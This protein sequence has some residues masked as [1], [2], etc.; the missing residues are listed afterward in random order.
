MQKWERGGA[1]LTYVLFEAEQKTGI[2][3]EEHE[4]CVGVHRRH[5][6]KNPYIYNFFII[7]SMRMP[8][9]LDIMA[10]VIGRSWPHRRGG[11]SISQSHTS[12]YCIRVTSAGSER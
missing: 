5:T 8:S 10:N 3:Q 7:S 1:K 9:A 4:T 11:Y 2:G 6:V 12:Y